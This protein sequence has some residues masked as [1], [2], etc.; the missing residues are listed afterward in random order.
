MSVV[1]S[2]GHFLNT[3]NCYMRGQSTVG[4]AVPVQVVLDYIRKVT[5]EGRGSK[6]GNCL[7][8]QSVLQFWAPGFFFC[9]EF[10]P[11][12]PLMTDCNL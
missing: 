2:V 5:E 6:L 7:P 10:L 3:A 9:L 1:M 12:L 8:P 4:S 11:L